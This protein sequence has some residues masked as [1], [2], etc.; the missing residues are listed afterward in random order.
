MTKKLATSRIRPNLDASDMAFKP[1]GR[2]VQGQLFNDA[3][4]ATPPKSPGEMSMDEWV[5]TQEPKFHGS[6]RSDFDRA[7]V[8]HYGT[9]GQAVE[10]LGNVSHT[11]QSSYASRDGYYNPSDLTDDDY[12]D[13]AGEERQGPYTHTGR[14]YARRFTTPASKVPLSDSAAN[15]AEMGYRYENY[16]EEWEIPK[17]VRESALQDA[18]ELS[19]D[20]KYDNP[21]AIHHS[22]MAKFGHGQ[23][24][25]GIPI[26]YRNTIEGHNPID[27]VADPV[28][29]AA[30]S[31]AVTSWERDVINEPRASQMSQQFAQQRIRQGKEGAVPFPSPTVR[32][33]PQQHQLPMFYD[34]NERAEGVA[35]NNTN[36]WFKITGNADRPSPAVRATLQEIQFEA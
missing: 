27:A 34:E 21:K 19:F 33:V 16:E 9:M 7:P 13:S 8:A 3:Q 23:L 17:S 35:P 31:S 28:S 18:P 11:L 2:T 32:Q 30:P 5:D 29:Y 14:V 4:F 15:A 25:Q 1:V 12:Y 10:R 36:R 20:A 6:F 22:E 26:K 24:E